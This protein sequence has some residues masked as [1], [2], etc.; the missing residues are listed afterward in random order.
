MMYLCPV[1]YT[2]PQ[3]AE[4]VYVMRELRAHYVPVIAIRHARRI[5]GHTAVAHS[6]VG[7]RRAVGIAAADRQLEH[8]GDPLGQVPEEA[9]GGLLAPGL[10]VHQGR[11]RRAGPFQAACPQAAPALRPLVQ[12][13]A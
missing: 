11:I 5:P 3:P 9:P 7:A 12:A 8:P 4:N 6:A 10:V 2:E 1:G 13:G